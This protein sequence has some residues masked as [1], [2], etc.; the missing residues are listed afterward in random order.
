MLDA[1]EP[2]DEQT[3]L[4]TNGMEN[5]VGVLG[6][7]GS[8]LGEARHCVIFQGSCHVTH[9]AFFACHFSASSWLAN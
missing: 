3:A 9:A 1:N 2:N 7:V 6:A 4:L 8:G 5:L